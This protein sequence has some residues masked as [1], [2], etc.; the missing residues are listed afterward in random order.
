M[1]VNVLLVDAPFALFENFGFQSGRQADKFAERD[2]HVH[3]YG[4]RDV[5]E[6]RKMGHVTVVGV[7]DEDP[8]TVLERARRAAARIGWE[9]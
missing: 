6:R 1:N 4:K 8:E 7:P 5:V 2:A 3:L 9:A